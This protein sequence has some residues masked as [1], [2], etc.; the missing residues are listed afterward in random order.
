MN[1]EF[2]RTETVT[3]I[4]CAEC[5]ATTEVRK[6][7]VTPPAAIGKAVEYQRAPNGWWIHGSSYFTVKA[8]CP[9]CFGKPFAGVMGDDSRAK[10]EARSALLE[11]ERQRPRPASRGDGAVDAPALQSV[12]PSML[13]TPGGAGAVAKALALHLCESITARG[14]RETA[15]SVRHDTSLLRIAETL[16]AASARLE[17]FDR[18]TPPT[19]I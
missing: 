16:E 17:E 4:T 9:A 18:R 7:E 3:R 10:Q 13:S 15:T 5:P 14:P 8:T 6:V 1:V 11:D 19:S 12:W 2:Q